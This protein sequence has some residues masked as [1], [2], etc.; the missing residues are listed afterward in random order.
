MNVLAMSKYSD[1][2]R[3]LKF[4]PRGAVKVQETA[5]PP[6]NLSALSRKNEIADK[7]ALIDAQEKAT[8]KPAVVEMSLP[9]FQ[10]FLSLFGK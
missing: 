1:V 10:H 5:L 8:N 2:E 7:W 6:I 4:A 3:F 9:V